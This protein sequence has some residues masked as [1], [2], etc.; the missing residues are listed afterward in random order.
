MVEWQL[1]IEGLGDDFET[2]AELLEAR[3]AAIASYPEDPLLVATFTD[4]PDLIIVDAVGA[5]LSNLGHADARIVTRRAEDAP[6][7]E[8]WRAIFSTFRASDRIDIAPVWEAERGAVPERI[9][10]VLDP[11]KAFGAGAHPTTAAVLDMLDRCLA[12]LETPAPRVLD[13]GSGTGI[14]AIAAAKLGAT[15]VG[16]EID[17]QACA[18]SIQNAALN[19]VADRFTVHH[20]SMDQVDDTFDVVVANIYDSLLVRL[21]SDIS[22]AVEGELILSGI[23]TERTDGVLAAYP[24]MRLVE[25]RDDRGW[26]TLWL[27]AG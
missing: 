19:G 8:G 14:L 21:A 16:V 25:R 23:Q 3:D 27:S 6:W 5:W 24:G 15:T 2:V 18:D 17:A 10:V 13:V 11:S 4:E 1:G 22:R 20:G 12:G 9:T 7:Q 26:T